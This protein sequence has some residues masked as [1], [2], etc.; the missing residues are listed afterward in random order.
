MV[1]MGAAALLNAGLNW[2]LVP[3]LGGLGAAVATAVSYLVWIVASMWISERLWPVGFPYLLLAAQVAVGVAAVACVVWLGAQ[4]WWSIVCVHAA[5]ALLL[6][7]SVSREGRG[8]LV[9]RSGLTH[10]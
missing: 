9:G 3:S 7:S 8:L 2:L 10:G 5:V 1:L 4:S 6:L